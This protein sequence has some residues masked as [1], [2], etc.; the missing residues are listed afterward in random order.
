M[1]ILKSQIC[2]LPLFSFIIFNKNLQSISIAMKRILIAT[3][4]NIT[5][6]TILTLIFQQVG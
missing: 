1:Y 3:G 5:L 6:F 2:I 4:C